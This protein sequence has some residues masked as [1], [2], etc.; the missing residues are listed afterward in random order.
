V[1]LHGVLLLEVLLNQQQAVD[2]SRSGAVQE[3]AHGAFTSFMC[4]NVLIQLELCRCCVFTELTVS[5]L[6]STPRST[7][8]VSVQD[9]YLVKQRSPADTR[10]Q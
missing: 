2:S 3:P 5:R 8:A 9:L 4:Q 1:Q 7:A 10:K 6:Q